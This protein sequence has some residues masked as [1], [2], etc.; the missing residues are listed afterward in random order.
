MKKD[1]TLIEAQFSI[2]LQ[3][4][5]LKMKKKLKGEEVVYRGDFERG[6]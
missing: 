4:G 1:A 3:D 5:N 6:N 2:G